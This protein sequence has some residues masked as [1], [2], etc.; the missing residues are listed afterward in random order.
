MP[1]RRPSQGAHMAKS[2]KQTMGRVVSALAAVGDIPVAATISGSTTERLENTG[3]RLK[4]MKM[5]DSPSRSRRNR[6]GVGARTGTEAGRWACECSAWSFFKGG[7]SLLIGPPGAWP[8][9]F[10]C[11]HDGRKVRFCLWNSAAH[12]MSIE[13]AIF[14]SGMRARMRFRCRRGCGH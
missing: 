5:T 13:S 4:A 12:T 14:A 6:E 7:R 8:T 11:A 10:W 1:T 9:P 3:R 2:P